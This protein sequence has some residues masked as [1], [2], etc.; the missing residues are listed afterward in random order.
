METLCL[1][2]QNFR[3][4][5][6]IAYSN[7]NEEWGG[8][9][10]LTPDDSFAECIFPSIAGKVDNKIFIIYHNDFEPGLYSFEIEGT[11]ITEVIY[12]EIDKTDFYD[13]QMNYE[14]TFNVDL[15]PALYNGSL[16]F[17]VNNDTIYLTGSMVNWAV[18]G[19]ENSIRMTDNNNDSIYYCTMSLSTGSYQYKYFK[20]SG[21][22]GGEWEGDPNR[23]VDVY[24][25]LVTDNIW[26]PYTKIQGAG[27]EEIRIFPNPAGNMLYF[28]NV[29]SGSS[30]KIAGIAGRRILEKDI[31][32]SDFSINISHLNQGLYFILITDSSGNSK[33]YRIVKK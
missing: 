22:E 24:D 7:L 11:A 9:I 12:S 26:Y 28:E 15:K 31:Y 19:N 5:Y 3:H 10:D 4:V 18:P 14:I 29:N 25:D 27:M 1:E 21:W 13:F 17:D 16:A 32:N 20:N 6:G 23:I 30:V 8:F 2:Y 33:S